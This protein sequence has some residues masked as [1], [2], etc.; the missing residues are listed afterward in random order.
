MSNHSDYTVLNTIY[1]TLNSA[2]GSCGMQL[3]QRR[4]FTLIVYEIFLHI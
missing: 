4:T 3:V 2:F 1:S